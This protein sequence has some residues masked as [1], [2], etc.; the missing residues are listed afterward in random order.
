MELD[1][2][3]VWLL[4]I[5]TLASIQQNEADLLYSIFK[6]FHLKIQ[7]HFARLIRSSENGTMLLI[8]QKS[9]KRISFLNTVATT[10][11]NSGLMG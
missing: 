8:S 1:N 4:M 9:W 3:L 7:H 6:Q 10:N 5:P 2:H 11:S